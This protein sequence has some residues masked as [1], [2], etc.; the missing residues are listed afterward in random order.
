MKSS[1][2]KRNASQRVDLIPGT[3]SKRQKFTEVDKEN[4]E[5]KQE[6]PLLRPRQGESDTSAYDQLNTLKPIPT[7]KLVTRR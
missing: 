4:Q 3:L 2:G 5:P 1:I 7:K 6:T